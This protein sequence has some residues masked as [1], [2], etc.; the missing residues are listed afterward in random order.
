MAGRAGDRL[1]HHAPV[2]QEHPRRQITRLA[3][4]RAKGRAHQRLRLLFDHRDQAVPHHLHPD[5]GE[6]FGIA[7]REPL[8]R[9]SS[10]RYPRLFTCASKSAVTTVVV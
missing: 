1:R 6:F 10:T 3:R 4:G 5:Q 9:C 8:L 2:G 7:H